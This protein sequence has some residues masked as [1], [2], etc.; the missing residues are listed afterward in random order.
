MNNN[1]G[2][3]NVTQASRLAAIIAIF[4]ATVLVYYNTL[5]NPLVWDDIY[6]IRD[7]IFIQDISNIT[8]IFSSEY[9]SQPV[10]I[11]YRPVATLTYMIEYFLWDVHT[12][13]YHMFNLVLHIMNAFMVL[14]IIARFTKRYW[15][16]VGAALLFA[17]H[18]VQTEAI[19]AITFREDLLAAF[20]CLASLIVYMKYRDGGSPAQL[21]FS[22]VLVLLAV[23]SKETAVVFPGVILAYEYYIR[24]EKSPGRSWGAAALFAVPVVF[25][26]IVRFGPMQGPQSELIYHGGGPGATA[27]IMIQAFAHYLNL[28]FWPAAQCVDYLFAENP[29]FGDPATLVSLFI[30][31]AAAGISVMFFLVRRSFAFGAAWFVLFMLPVSN[32][33]PIGVVMAER[34]LYIASAG[35]FVA[36]AVAA[37]YLFVSGER[38]FPYLNSKALTALL[39][40]AIVA[41]GAKTYA[42]NQVWDS[43]V[44]FWEAACSCA[45]KSARAAVNLGLAYLDEEQLDEAGR[46]LVVAVRLASE[47][48]QSDIRYGSL[49][50]AFTNLGIVSARQG[51]LETAVY[52]FTEA[53]K[54]NPEAASP[55]LN[56]G[57]AS[58]KLGRLDVAKHA[59]EKGLE[60]SDFN[61]TASLYLAMVYHQLGEIRRAIDTCNGILAVVPDHHRALVLKDY[62]LMELERSNE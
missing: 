2:N 40:V 11:S 53:A 22:L 48:K 27:V 4:V 23:F 26:L 10:E 59:L 57:V 55:Y 32:I 25:Y 34:Y 62:L 36:L 37:D 16:S 5:D 13:G 41:A 58:I 33:I 44:E 3:N 31:I 50:R 28:L 51:R 54:Y 17:L 47:G 60:L 29:S 24:N 56:I 45:P 43:R 46:T 15:L 8:K 6:L 61:P 42:R 14:T 21:V 30:L 1:P 20:F 12:D 35:F 19:N 39:A 18:P 38:P 9:F 52:F 49:Y 7:N